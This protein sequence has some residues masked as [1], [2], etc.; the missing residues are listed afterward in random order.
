MKFYDMGFNAEQH[1]FNWI[2]FYCEG[3]RLALVNELSGGQPARI[4]FQ[5]RRGG[6]IRATVPVT[7]GVSPAW[8]TWSKI[9][10]RPGA[11]RVALSLPRRAQPGHSGRG[12]AEYDA[13]RSG[14]VGSHHRGYRARADPGIGRLPGT[15]RSASHHGRADPGTVPSGSAAT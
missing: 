6:K 1:R 9:S 7:V 12:K 5:W 2:H 15:L 11:W 8:R 3:M 14:N 13:G 10:L 4:S